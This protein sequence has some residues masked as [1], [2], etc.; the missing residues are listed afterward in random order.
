VVLDFV[1]EDD[2]P[3]QALAMVKMGGYYFVVGYGGIIEVPT[4]EMI[5]TEKNFIGKP[6]RDYRR[7]LGARGFSWRGQGLADHLPLRARRDQRCDLGPPRGPDKGRGVVGPL[8]EQRVTG[9]GYSSR[10]L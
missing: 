9:F 7:A 10:I 3:A 4:I 8:D 2:V 1:G 5:T 6:G